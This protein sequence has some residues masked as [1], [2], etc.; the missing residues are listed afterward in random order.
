MEAAS[1]VVEL[2]LC[3][4][5]EDNIAVAVNNGDP[6]HDHDYNHDRNHDGA[7]PPGAL[8]RWQ[9]RTYAPVTFDRRSMIFV[10][11]ARPPPRAAST[12]TMARGASCASRQLRLALRG[13]AHRAPTFFVAVRGS[14]ARVNPRHQPVPHP[15]RDMGVVVIGEV[16]QYTRASVR[17]TLCSKYL[18]RPRSEIDFQ[19]SRRRAPPVMLR[20]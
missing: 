15:Q 16:V 19:L 7:A 20:A 3:M 10:S 14:V 11:L 2:Q 18:Q 9:G 12:L 5:V 6:G 4:S 8:L 17:S 1:S 13:D